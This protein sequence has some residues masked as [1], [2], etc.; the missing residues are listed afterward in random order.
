V[1]GP[2]GTKKQGKGVEMIST[3]FKEFIPTMKTNVELED[4][5]RSNKQAIEVMKAADGNHY[6]EVL[7]AFKEHK[8]KITN[9]SE[10]K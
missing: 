2:D 4:F 1:T 6:A 8:K 5:W 3:I 10:D 9:G 7:N